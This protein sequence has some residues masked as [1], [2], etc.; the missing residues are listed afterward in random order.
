MTISPRPRKSPRPIHTR[1]QSFGAILG[2]VLPRALLLFTVLLP[3]LSQAQPRDARSLYRSG[4]Q[5]Y[6]LAEYRQALEDFKAAYRATPDPVFL[7]NIAQCH[8]QLHEYE[9]AATFYRSYRRES[10]EAPNRKEV[11][12][13][14]LQMEQA[15]AEQRA[16]QPPIGTQPPSTDPPVTSK[17]PVQSTPTLVSSPVREQPRPLHKRPW[18]WVGISGAVV[19]VATAVTLGVVLGSPTDP[20][21][22]VGRV[23]GD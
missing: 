10:P 12:R 22:S 7:F 11:E 8:R 2:G 9:E 20:S 6:N 5:H 18:F 16:R 14:I 15:V 3:A 19:V 4:T 1:R 17:V 23:P 13:L 21:P